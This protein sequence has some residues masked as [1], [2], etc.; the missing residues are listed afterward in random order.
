MSAAQTLGYPKG[1]LGHSA[2]VSLCLPSCGR[3]WVEDY[4][5]QVEH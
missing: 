4:L 5:I 1:R 2:G 3:D